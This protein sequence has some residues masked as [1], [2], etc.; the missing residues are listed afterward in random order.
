[1][2]IESKING[3]GVAGTT[4]TA[5][6]IGALLRRGTL[7]LLALLLAGCGDVEWFPESERAP[8]TPDAFS[9]PAKTNTAKAT[10]ITSDAITVAGLTAAASISVAGSQGSDSKYSINGGTPTATAGT[11]K[12]DDTVTVTHLSSSSLG[13]ATESTLT[14]GGVSSKFVSTTVYLD[15][16][17]FTELRTVEYNGSSYRRTFA[18]IT[19]VDTVTGNHVISITDSKVPPSGNAQYAVTAGTL[20][21]TSDWSSETRTVPVLNGRRIYV[22]SLTATVTL[23]VTTTLIINGVRY[24]V[25]LAIP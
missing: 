3:Q 15:T 17:T 1:M 7:L 8:T 13:T 18:T 19:S 5:R 9:F 23:P 10:E 20:P 16:P 21:V 22:R 6:A 14:I 2:K 25:N 11:V 24:D 12:N 4:G